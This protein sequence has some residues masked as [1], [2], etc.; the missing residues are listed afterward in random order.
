MQYPPIASKGHAR[1]SWSIKVPWGLMHRIGE[2]R[3]RVVAYGK[4]PGLNGVITVPCIKDGCCWSYRKYA[5]GDTVLEGLEKGARE[6]KKGLWIDP[7]PIPPWG[8]RKARRAERF[9]RSVRR[10]WPRSSRNSDRSQHPGFLL[11][12][13]Q[14]RAT[15]RSSRWRTQTFFL[16][17]RPV[18]D[19]DAQSDP[20]P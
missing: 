6:A 1:T 2:L 12:D 20:C 19:I 14:Q 17:L 16:L 15:R 13:S 7:A 4:I 3:L 10:R 18:F 11:V 5:P 8:Y 9:G